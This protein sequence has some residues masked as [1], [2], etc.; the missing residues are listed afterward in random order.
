MSIL[1]D[2]TLHELSVAQTLTNDLADN[3]TTMG[4]PSSNDEGLDTLV[5]KVLTIPTGGGGGVAQT[6]YEE[7]QE[8]F[9][10]NWDSVIANA[11]IGSFKVLHLYQKRKFL[12]LA[13][14]FPSTAQCCVWSKNTNA[15]RVVDIFYK[16]TTIP[17]GTVCK[18]I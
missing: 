10:V 17:E 5:P 9:G 7:W 12:K 6:T 14:D 8:G 18:L 15:Y 4:V 1:N 11:P 16:L 2:Q 3:L 13:S